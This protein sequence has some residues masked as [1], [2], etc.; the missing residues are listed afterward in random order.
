MSGLFCTV[1]H[2]FDN[3]GPVE[4]MNA[5]GVPVNNFLGFPWLYLSSTVATFGNT[6]QLCE[7]GWPLHWFL[8]SNDIKKYI[9]AYV[10]N[11]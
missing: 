1:R 5:A 9:L 2:N 8:Y 11:R 4:F 3:I 10:D 6:Q 7:E